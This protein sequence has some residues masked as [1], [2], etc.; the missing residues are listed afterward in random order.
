MWTELADVTYCCIIAVTYPG[1]NALSLYIYMA[2][3]RA[4]FYLFCRLTDAGGHSLHLT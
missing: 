4:Q 3:P 2:L 1:N